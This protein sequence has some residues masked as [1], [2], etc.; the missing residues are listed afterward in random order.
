M[1][2]RE[3]KT[4]DDYGAALFAAYITAFKGV[5]EV[6]LSIVRAGADAPCGFSEFAKLLDD[7]V[8]I[9]DEKPAE[10]YDNIYKI[11]A[12]NKHYSDL[13]DGLEMVYHYYL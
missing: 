6:V 5:A 13:K 3:F 12:F 7:G 8:V 1:T 10:H 9:T 4:V 11:R 2:T